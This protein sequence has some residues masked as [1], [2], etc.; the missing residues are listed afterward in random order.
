MD[1]KLRDLAKKIV[2]VAHTTPKKETFSYDTQATVTRVEGDIA[3]VHIPGGIVE[4]PV[5][6]T[7]Q[8]STNDKVMV[9]LAGG[10]A[11]ITGNNSA[12]PTD[13]VLAMKAE[14]TAKDAMDEINKLYQALDTLQAM[15]SSATKV[16]T[17]D[18]SPAS[19][20]V[21]YTS[22]L[23]AVQI[24][25]QGKVCWLWGCLKN[26]SPVDSSQE[27]LLFTLPSKYRPPQE[28]L[29]VMQGSGNCRWMLM[30][31]PNGRV[32]LSRYAG[33]ATSTSWVYETVGTG[34][35]INI[36]CSWILG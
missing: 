30:I 27:Q 23:P 34:S 21:A 14:K 33:S 12:P 25:R 13:N 26:T 24:R 11:W 31:R 32:T 10:D 16:E 36:N 28:V 19:P 4:T 22:T 15:L 5:K 8:A 1:K 3:W 35:W 20:F 2:T 9:R 17:E 7:I 29:G 18:L 6:L